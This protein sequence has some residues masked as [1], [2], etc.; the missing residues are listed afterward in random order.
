MTTDNTNMT[1]EIDSDQAQL[2]AVQE[3]PES[4]AT[5]TDST[6]EEIRALKQL[7]ETQPK[8]VA[9]LQ[10]KV[11]KGLNSS[12]RDSEEAVRK[13]QE[14]ALQQ[15]LE[16]V[17][18]EHRAAFQQIAQQNMQLQQQVNQ[19]QYQEPAQEQTPDA[20]SEWE[21][22]YAIPRSMG[23]DPQSEGIDYAAFTDPGLNDTQRRERFFTS[24]KTVMS[25]NN[26]T[27]APPPATPQNQSQ[28][29]VQNPPTGG[30]PAGGVSGNMRSVADLERAYI[31][32][33]ISFNDYKKRLAELG[34]R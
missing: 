19:S 12:R 33:G 7:I 14:Y 11:D 30:T 3:A 34:Q 21:Q 27:Q 8:Q 26:Q 17:P 29:E 24:I 28:P 16:Q 15:Y 31:S 20:S 6:T 1:S 9:G 4:Q 32:D 13:Q 22:I 10:S 18:E 5:T 25:G 2:D 23:L